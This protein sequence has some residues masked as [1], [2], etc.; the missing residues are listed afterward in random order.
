ML[1]VTRDAYLR[2][3]EILSKRPE[4]VAARIVRR[5]GRLKLR[6]GRRR[7][8][9]EVFVHEGRTVL[10]LDQHICEH[11]QGRILDVRDT[12]DGPRLRFRRSK[13]QQ[14]QS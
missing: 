8:G 3:S 5:D 10:L 9:D 12:Q 1:N 4:N 14:T 11:L 2:L 6:R 13:Q 7:R